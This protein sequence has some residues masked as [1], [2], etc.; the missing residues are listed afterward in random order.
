M[1]DTRSQWITAAVLATLI[2]ATYLNW[3]WAWGLLFIYWAVPSVMTGEAFL[4]T[5]IAR[6]DSPVLFWM[7]TVMWAGFGVWA[8]AA[9]LAW[10]LG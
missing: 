9:D 7:I 1:F 3:Y 10:R 2:V 6:A 5:P 8:V 4:V